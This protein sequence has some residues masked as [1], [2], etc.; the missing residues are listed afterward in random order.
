MSGGPINGVP[1]SA[2]AGPLAALPPEGIAAI[3]AAR[4]GADTDDPV[5]YTGIIIPTV[6]QIADDVL[7]YFTSMTCLYDRYW[8]PDTEKVTLPIC[9]F[10]VTKI[11]PNYQIET[12]SK[13]LLVY[14]QKW[15]E[16]AW[17]RADGMRNT[18]MK[19]VIENSGS[20]LRRT[21][22]RLSSRS[23]RQAVMSWEALKCSPT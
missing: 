22:W 1:L 23:S 18:A 19:S 21:A 7:R 5:N 8:T 17:E 10:H 16:T 13:R 14:E 15:Q 11:T 12:S 9:T 2:M 6:L 4:H 20:S 3:S